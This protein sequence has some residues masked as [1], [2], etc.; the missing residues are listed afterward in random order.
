MSCCT[1]G[2]FMDDYHYYFAK[3]MQCHP[4]E[5]QLKRAKHDWRAGSTGW[6]GVQIA[7]ELIKLAAQKAAEKPLVNIGGNNYAHQGSELAIKYS[8]A[9]EP[10]P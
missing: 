1:L 2:V 5:A 3:E 10:K 6:E 9:Q 7:K 8:A 4:T